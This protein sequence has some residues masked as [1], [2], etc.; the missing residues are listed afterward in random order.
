M[1]CFFSA[2]GGVGCSLVTAAAS[3]LSARAR[4]TL[5][6][7]LAGGLWHVLGVAP[8]GAGD[9][10]AAENQWVGPP[11]LAQWL[12]ASDP[13]PDA[14]RY[15]EVDVCD[16]L[17]LLPFGARSLPVNAD[18]ALVDERARGL[19]RTLAA[20]DRQV[21][22]DVGLNGDRLR[23]LLDAADRSL[24]VTR[25]CY[26]ALRAT[27]GAPRPGEVVLIEEPGRA[28]TAS[29]VARVVDAPVVATVPW[30]PAIARAVDAGL[31]ASRLPGSLKRLDAVAT[32]EGGDR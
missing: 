32:S 28:L 30:L 26:L 16:G 27:I 17:R 23:P 13:T 20:D 10:A 19:A 21:L 29:D 12:E 25:A 22:V 8:P 24:L 1:L 2:K 9:A 18:P 4:P 31:L 6:V 15:L 11:G 5:V 3:I 14:L 7:D